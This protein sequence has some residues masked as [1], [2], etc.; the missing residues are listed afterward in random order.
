MAG[1]P[2][3]RLKTAIHQEACVCILQWNDEINRLN[4]YIHHWKTFFLKTSSV[5]VHLSADFQRFYIVSR[6]FCFTSVQLL[7]EFNSRLIWACNG[8]SR[9][10]SS[11]E[12]Q[13]CSKFA[14]NQ[15][16]WMRMIWK[17]WKDAVATE[18]DA[19][20][21]ANATL[22]LNIHHHY[23]FHISSFSFPIQRPIRFDFNW[24]TRSIHNL[25]TQVIKW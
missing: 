6:P 7:F 5:A 18:L 20:L 4:Q 25:F 19:H 2:P 8:S 24:N 22:L 21:L 16:Q 13:H 1:I 3:F 17:C 10:I 14:A 15:W 9:F 23:N 11:N 12:R